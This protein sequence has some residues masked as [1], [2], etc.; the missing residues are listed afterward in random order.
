MNLVVFCAGE[1]QELGSLKWFLRCSVS[2]LGPVYGAFTFSALRVLRGDAC[3]GW[4]HHSR[5]QICLHPESSPWKKNLLLGGKAMTNLD[6]VL[7]SRDFTLRTKVPES[8]GFSRSHVWMWELGYKEGW[9][10]KNWCI[11]TVELEKTIESPLDR[12]EI[13]PGN[14]QGNHSWIF[15]G[16]TDAGAD[17]PIFWPPEWFIGKDPDVG[18]DWRQERGWQRM[19]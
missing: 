5:Q 17:T 2:Y 11:W 15:I 10:L 1:V 4:G 3:S 19:G 8:Y 12:K 6:S 14:P 13:Q 16:R 18:K 9:V 7:K